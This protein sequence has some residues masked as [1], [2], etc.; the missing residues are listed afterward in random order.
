V[1][2]T[3]GFKEIKEIRAYRGLRGLKEIVKH[4]GL[5]GFEE[6]RIC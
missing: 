6:F 5:K 2:R 3:W 4:R 1:Q